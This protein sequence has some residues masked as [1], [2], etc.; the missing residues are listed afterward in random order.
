MDHC[1]S[2]PP[3]MRMGQATDGSGCGWVRLRVGQAMFDGFHVATA[4]MTT[5]SSA[6]IRIAHSG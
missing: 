2:E 6:M 4:Q 5:R 1:D 3:E